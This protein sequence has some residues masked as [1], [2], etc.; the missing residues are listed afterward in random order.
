MSYYVRCRYVCSDSLP[1]QKS[2]EY[3]SKSTKDYSEACKW[4]R[5]SLRVCKFLFDSGIMVSYD[6]SIDLVGGADDE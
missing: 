2:G 6:I 5:E 4:K 3:R 1:W